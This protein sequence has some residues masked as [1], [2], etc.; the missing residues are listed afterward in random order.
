[1]VKFKNPWAITNSQPSISMSTKDKV[2]NWGPNQWRD[3]EK[4]STFVDK[5]QREKWLKYKVKK[6]ETFQ[7]IA[8]KFCLEGDAS[9]LAFWNDLDSTDPSQPHT[10]TT[11]YL[12]FKEES[13]LVAIDKKLDEMI[14][15][16]KE[17]KW[18]V[19]IDNL[20]R[21]RKGIAGVKYL[22]SSWLKEFE[23]V[24]EAVT[25]IQGH[26]ED[27]LNDIANDMEDGQSIKGDG[28]G[29]KKG[30]QYWWQGKIEP[31]FVWSRNE[32][33]F[34]CG[35]SIL[36]GIGIVTL[37]RKEDII[38]ISGT[39][40][41]DFF[42]PYDWHG[43]KTVPIGLFSTFKDCDMLL[44]EEYRGAKPF[45]MKSSWQQQLAGTIE[46]D[47]FSPNEINLTWSDL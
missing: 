36:T 40:T 35:A 41:Y 13:D 32:L 26:F 1:M 21:Y 38:T 6:G 34:A 10:G 11:I 5:S 42:D 45:E 9:D 24:Q 39:V 44:L 46:D 33:S 23:E 25:T 27:S 7:Q 18:D 43:G 15:T 19:A 28:S 29:K 16:A 4:D 17:Q 31:S 20:Q 47:T 30:N 37:S 2:V 8:N 14:I 22:D 12:I 3:L